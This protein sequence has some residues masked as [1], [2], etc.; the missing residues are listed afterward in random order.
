MHRP[1]R[2]AVIV[3]AVVAVVLTTV[4]IVT[5]LDLGRQRGRL[6][7]VR[8]HGW[9]GFSTHCHTSPDGGAAGRFGDPRG[10]FDVPVDIGTGAVAREALDGCPIPDGTRIDDDHTYLVV[11]TNTDRDEVR[12]VGV[13]QGDPAKLTVEWYYPGHGCGVTSEWRGRLVL[14]LEGPSGAS[15]TDVA[16]HEVPEPC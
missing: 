8:A 1:Q 14:V 5:Y 16:V 10:R 15:T 13:E 7:V 12:L 3:L 11:A 4:A 2:L 9:S 6:P